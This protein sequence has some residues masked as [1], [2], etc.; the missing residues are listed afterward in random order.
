VNFTSGITTEFD[1]ATSGFDVNTAAK[2]GDKGYVN[3][4]ASYYDQKETNRAGQ[5]GS[6]ALF[7]DLVGLEDA[8]GFIDANPDLGMH[9]GTPNMTSRDLFYNASV[10]LNENTEL[11][12]F[13]GI[14]TRQ[15]LSYALYRA[16]Y[17]IGD[18]NDLFGEGEDYDGFQPTFET[19]IFDKT[20]RLNRLL[21]EILEN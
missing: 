4:T 21:N 9:V 8:T 16:P 15:G 2:I 7:I 14:T 13:G 20:Y 1:G 10:D 11:Y 12:S 18:P 5:P 17:W 3:I 19:D 6:D